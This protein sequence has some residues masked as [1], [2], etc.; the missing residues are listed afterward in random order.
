MIPEQ[1][2]WSEFCAPGGV[3]K[4]HQ[5]LLS[6]GVSLRIISFYPPSGAHSMPVM[7]LPG[8]TSVILSFKY[9]M[10]ELTRYFVVHWV[11]TREKTSSIVP[12][13][14]RYDLAA[15]GSDIL[16]VISQL[17]FVH[18]KFILIGASLNA[19][20]II[21]RYPYL[22]VKPF[23]LAL[24]EPNAIFDYPGWSLAY[25][26]F[27]LFT[28]RI[29]SRILGSS[30]PN[31]GRS[32][33]IKRFGKW[34]L[35]KFRMNMEEDEE[36]YRIASRAIDSANPFKLGSTIIAI[37]PYQIWDH[38]SAIQTPT[39]LLCASSDTFHRQDDI[40]KISSMIKDCTYTDLQVH[41]R[42]NGKDGA[43]HIRAYIDTLQDSMKQE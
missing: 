7:M 21:D 40:S 1:E 20:S 35:K 3:S 15:I 14:A 8:L 39:L 10:L 36:M 38:L 29:K 12:K 23:C 6:N 34:Y 43:E 13:G 33:L 28:Y 9:F 31:L 16:E 2:D 42:T 19:T 4:Q 30:N 37:S 24:L 41:E 5:V 18:Q 25:I 27:F 32:R 17:G 22:K 26:R 11:E